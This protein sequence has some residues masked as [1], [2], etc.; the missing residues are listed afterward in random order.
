MA[1]HVG[2]SVHLY[3]ETDPLKTIQTLEYEWQRRSGS[4]SENAVGQS[5][6]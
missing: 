6:D 4:E 3:T 5:V 2:E 1:C